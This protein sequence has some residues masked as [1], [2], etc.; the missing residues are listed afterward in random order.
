VTDNLGWTAADFDTFSI[1]A[2]ADPRL[3]GGGGYTVSGLYNVKPARFSVPA[4]NYITFADNYGK[5]TRRWDGVDVTVNARP[6]PGLMF[7]GGTSSGRTTTDNCDIVDDMPELLVRLNLP[8]AYCR[9]QSRF[10]TDLKLLGTYTVPRIDVQV[11][12]T[13]QS[14]PGPQILANYV[15]TN[16]VVQPSLGRPLSGN[17]ANMTVQIVEPGTM[18]GE[19]S[20]QV[21]LRLTK[22]LRVAGTRATASVDVY[23]VLNA[24]PVLSMSSAFATWQRPESI[25]N[26]RWAKF[27]L[28]LDF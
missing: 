22:I 14:V 2:P 23:N 16:A 27:V 10:L 8:V 3:P 18:Y 15:A 7:Q 25:P 11:A 1:T 19:R 17:A 24:N 5:Q 28:Q 12:A 9:Q 21:Q 4:D 20:N 6:A 26:P 13:V